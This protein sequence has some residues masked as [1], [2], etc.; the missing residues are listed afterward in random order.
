MK[1]VLTMALM[2]AL[3]LSFTSCID[4]ESDDNETK[5]QV[6][7]YNIVKDLHDDS[8]P[9]TITQSYTSFLFNYTKS[10]LTAD[11]QTML[12]GGLS[13][14]FNTGEIKMTA[15][16]RGFSFALPKA[17]GTGLNIEGLDGLFDPNMGVIKYNY[18]VN[19]DYTVSAVSGFNYNFT[20]F[21][22]TNIE[23][24]VTELDNES[25]TGFIVQPDLTK[26]TL[27]L[28][29]NNFYLAGGSSSRIQR[30]DY[31]EIP[32][33]LDF[34]GID[35][36]VK[37]ETKSNQGYNDCVIKNLSI[38]LY[39]LGLKTEISFDMNNHHYTATGY[40]FYNKF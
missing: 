4:S 3:A 34:D 9:V 39:G 1:K 11:V 17:S 7:M 40:L 12:P 20:R 23:T 30:I 29:F 32:Y 6:Y 25:Q 18:Q 37:D 28:S 2:A 5:A 31:S 19:G 10:T 38:N 21:V 26:K 8:A 15:G 24:G 16:T 33:T 35:A 27:T 36:Y 14:R 22:A 13:G